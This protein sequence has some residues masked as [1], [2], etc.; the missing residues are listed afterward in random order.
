MRIA[1]A[2]GGDISGGTLTLL[3]HHMTGTTHDG[4]TNRI[5]GSLTGGVRI[6]TIADYGLRAGFN[7]GTWILDGPATDALLTTDNITGTIQL[8]HGKLT[9]E[10]TVKLAYA[11]NTAPETRY[12]NGTLILNNDAQLLVTAAGADLIVG[13]GAK[14]SLTSGT[15]T[16]NGTSVVD[17]ARDIRVGG[18]GGQYRRSRGLMTVNGGTVTV[19]RDLIVTNTGDSASTGTLD[20]LGGTVTADNEFHGEERAGKTAPPSMR[21]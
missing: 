16:V 13:A 10:G 21:R 1:L 2:F 19:G 3:A 9:G 6:K 4:S 18:D 14:N 7:N 12:F 15:L 11:N 5:S 17:V 20:I 8:D